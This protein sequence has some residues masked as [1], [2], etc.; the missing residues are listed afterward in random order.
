MTVVAACV[1]WLAAVAIDARQ[2][3]LN[4]RDLNVRDLIVRDLIVLDDGAYTVEQATRGKVH[5][6]AFCAPCHLGDLS[7][8]LAADAGAP[9]RRCAALLSGRRCNDRAPPAFSTT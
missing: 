9:P 7:G 4:V 3:D 1:A 2:S 5:Y 8:T 6:Q